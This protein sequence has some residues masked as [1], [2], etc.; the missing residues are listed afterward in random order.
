L[1][2]KVAEILTEYSHIQEGKDNLSQATNSSVEAIK[3]INDASYEPL[4]H[5]LGAA[6]VDI[7]A[8][9]DK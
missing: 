8:L 6:G 3:P 1:V 4:R 7:Q 9:I 2:Q 5:Y